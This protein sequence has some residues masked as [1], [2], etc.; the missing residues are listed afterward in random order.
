MPYRSIAH[1]ASEGSGLTFRA[2]LSSNIFL[3]KPALDFRSMY[4]R[5]GAM[6]G[7]L[8]IKNTFYDLVEVGE[9]LP[10]RSQ[11][12]PPRLFGTRQTSPKSS[13]RRA[14][15]TA[16]KRQNRSGDE[17]HALEEFAAVARVE[18]WAFVAKK[19]M[20]A[21][22]RARLVSARRS[23]PPVPDI[24]SMQLELPKPLFMELAA[25]VFE[26][27]G[28]ILFLVRLGVLKPGADAIQIWSAQACLNHDVMRI[29][30]GTGRGLISMANDGV[31]HV[32]WGG[33]RPIVLRYTAR[34]RLEDLRALLLVQTL[35]PFR[36]VHLRQELVGDGFLSDYGVGPG[37]CILLQSPIVEL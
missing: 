36:L 4:D 14:R 30:L 22:V 29:L 37:S 35:P 20:A 1:A 31:F 21:A 10:K 16:A 34:F 28:D 12:A 23:L 32:T 15:R 9:E 2:E 19:L 5:I 11:S 6:A 3:P 13:S 7:Q 18:R 8:V 17:D 27:E 26:T 25:L 33:M 24:P